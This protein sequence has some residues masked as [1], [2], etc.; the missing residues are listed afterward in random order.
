MQTQKTKQQH[1]SYLWDGNRQ[2]QQNTATH[3][4]TII[5]EQ[6]SFEP[7]A[8]F[9]WLRDGLTAANDEP[10]TNDEGW[11]GNNKPVIKTGVQLYHYH[12]D[13]LGTPNELTDQQGEV[14][15]YADYEA[16]GNTATVEWKAQRIDNI[17]VSEA[18]LQPIRFQGQSFDTETGLHYNR[19]RYFDPDLGI[20]TSRDPIGL[21]G[22]TNVFAYAPNPTGWIDPFGLT[23]TPSTYDVGLYGEQRKGLN[24]K[25]LPLDSHHV[26]QKNIMKD[27]VTNY[28]PQKAPAIVVPREGH[29]KGKGNLPKGQTVVSRSKINGNTGKPFSSARDLLARDISEL[30]RVYPDIPNSTLKELIDLNKSTYP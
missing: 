6:D 29:T 8:Q 14:V 9:I 15:W 25:N 21:N 28:D 23:P 16:W 11:Y 13:H 24:G 7:V 12:N 1:T 26:G 10:E 18:H 17:V 20:F 27:L 3:T 5:Y 2:L 4:H 22:G 19:F 30:R